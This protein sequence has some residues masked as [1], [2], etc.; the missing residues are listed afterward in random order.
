M[1]E[2]E[3]M[4][5]AIKEAKDGNT[6][7]GCIIARNGEVVAR[8][9]NTVQPDHDPTEHAEMNA[10]RAASRKYNRVERKEMSVYTTCEPCPMCMSALIFGG[11]GEVVYGTNI[12][13]ASKYV[14]QIHISS[15]EVREKAGAETKVKSEVLVRDCEDLFKQY[16]ERK[17]QQ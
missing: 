9:H 4:Q 16:K 7:F 12:D 13:T 2:N 17:Q 6:P 3:L 8:A 10:L 14:H 1:T 11:F 5:E 15:E